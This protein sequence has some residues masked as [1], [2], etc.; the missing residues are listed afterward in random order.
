MA[1]LAGVAL[2]AVCVAAT[3]L[4]PALFTD[5]VALEGADYD[6]LHVHRIRYL[7]DALFG[8]SPHLPAW[9]TREALG[10]PFWSNLH[11]VPFNPLRWCVVLLFPAARAYAWSI[12][13]CASFAAVCCYAYARQ[14]KLGPVAAWAAAWTFACSGFF[15]ARVHA[16]HLP[17]LEAYPF[18]PLLLLLVERY[19]LA[20]T[21]ASQTLGLLVLALVASA[22]GL[23][24]HPQVPFYVLVTSA[25]YALCLLPWKRGAL[26]A[27]AMFFGVGL[28]APVLYP[29]AQLSGR[30][31]RFL[32]LDPAGNSTAFTSDLFWR[33]VEPLAIGWQGFP[34]PGFS[35]PVKSGAIFYDCA[36]YTGLLAVTALVA[37]PVLY[38]KQRIRPSRTQL[39]LGGLGVVAL[40]MATPILGLIGATFVRS[41]SRILVL[42]VFVIA[43]AFGYALEW[44]GSWLSARGTQRVMLLPM[45]LTAIQV[46]DLGLHDR[47]YIHTRQ[48]IDATV[49][50]QFNEQFLADAQGWR[51]AIPFNLLIYPNRRSD[52]VGFFDAIVLAP[53]YRAVLALSGRPPTSNTESFSA[54]DSMPT[55]GLAYLGVHVVPCWSG[56]Q[57]G[58]CQVNGALPRVRFLS[59]EHAEFLDDTEIERRLR[60]PLTLLGSSVMLQPSAEA[61]VTGMRL[62]GRD[63]SAQAAIECNRPNS[64][65]IACRVESTGP[66]YL[67]IAETWDPGWY[68][69]INGVLMDPLL[70]DGFMMA[71]PIAAPGRHE[72]RLRYSTPGVFTG[73]WLGLMAGLGLLVV[74]LSPHVQPRPSAKCL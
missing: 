62:R 11:S 2:L 17:V 74:V 70:A 4:T 19:R 53:Y 33:F 25:V 37:L 41:P 12:V 20:S 73:L 60:D 30:S 29:M 58:G 35:P 52:D 26:A 23:S 68:A 54:S 39:F 69:Y 45:A 1:E 13:G 22:L 6:Q 57:L 71:L 34:Q 27:A 21:P 63:V 55:R 66:G 56:N 14:L 15:A 65:E 32:A 43:L 48:V 24:G 3:Y 28:G 64:D 59:A 16:G 9:Y 18:L 50:Q 61:A 31:S 47:K 67:V 10:T 44:I 46:F 5:G 51:V 36:V 38:W 42:V 8:D 49:D 40:L 7:Q 72:L